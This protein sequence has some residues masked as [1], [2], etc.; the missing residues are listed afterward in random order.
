MR[1]FSQPRFAQTCLLHSCPKQGPTGTQLHG[2]SRAGRGG[3]TRPLSL[4]LGLSH[5]SI[6]PMMC[7]QSRTCTQVTK[8]RVTEHRDFGS[9]ASVTWTCPGCP[10]RAGL[11]L[12][13]GLGGKAKG[14]ENCFAAAPARIASRLLHNQQNLSTCERTWGLTPMGRPCSGTCS[15]IVVWLDGVA[16]GLVWLVVEGVSV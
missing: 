2:L 11:S 8:R 16:L 1:L 10:C 9:A 7:P 5:V 14:E 6:P 3:L 15:V 12:V 4:F 13:R